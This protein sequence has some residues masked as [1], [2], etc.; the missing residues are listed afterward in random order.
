LHVANIYIHLLDPLIHLGKSIFDID[1]KAVL[2]EDGFVVDIV[3]QVVVG[4]DIDISVGVEIGI[5][6]D[7]DVKV[8]ITVGVEDGIAIDVDAEVDLP[9]VTGSLLWWLVEFI[10]D[11][12]PVSHLEEDKDAS[13][14][15]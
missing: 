14:L 12:T 8:S 13:S 9:V 15:V 2:V 3:R 10:V 1:I 7:I 11:I 6:G 4:G 5:M